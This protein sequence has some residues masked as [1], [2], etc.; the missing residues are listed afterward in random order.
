MKLHLPSQLTTRAVAVITLAAA[1][2]AQSVLAQDAVL[3]EGPATSTEIDA[4]DAVEATD[5]RLNEIEQNRRAYERDI[6]VYLNEISDLEADQGPYASNLSQQLLGL[7]ELYAAIGD[8]PAAIRQFT[9]SIHLT[10]VNS[11]LNN[12]EQI[13]VT[14]SLIDSLLAMGDLET[15]D[16]RQRYLYYI[17]R[18]GYGLDDPERADAMMRY[19]DWQRR[20]YLADVGKTSYTRLLSMYDIYTKVHALI[21]SIHGNHALEL[22]VPLNG[23]VES[24][25]L[26]GRYNG[27][28]GYTNRTLRDSALEEGGSID[29]TRVSRLSQVAFKRGRDAIEAMRVIYENNPDAPPFGVPENT[30]ALA[31]WF[32]MNRKH[33]GAHR[34]YARAWEEMGNIP[35]G[36]ERRAELLGAPSNLPRGI[37]LSSGFYVRSPKSEDSLGPGWVNLTYIVNERGRANDFEVL[38]AHPSIDDP[39]IARTLRK[40]KRA[41]F[42]P[43]FA[44]GVPVAYNMEKRHDF[45]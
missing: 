43:A 27:E 37:D 7:G 15:A 1:I 10:R 21:R 4:V 45:E 30:I 31:D 13:P 8:H 36:E 12:V 40:L 38:E 26:L 18:E 44:D 17:S 2:G 28:H 9:R 39:R 33:G 11:G 5:D 35:G 22:L 24:H 16:E 42:R 23:L 29:E 14:N 32:L 3:P 25:F 19:A 41:Q 20:T 34:L 6:A